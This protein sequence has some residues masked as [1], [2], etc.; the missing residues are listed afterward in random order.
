V[1]GPSD[2]GWRT[3]NIWDDEAAFRWFQRERL[4]RAAGLAVQEE[5]FDSAKAAAFR[6]ATSP[7][8]S[9]SPTRHE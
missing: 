4:V 8:P 5:G 1:A 9:R 3:I 6:S 7:G 2:E